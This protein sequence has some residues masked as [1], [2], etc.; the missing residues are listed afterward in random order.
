MQNPIL[1]VGST[2]KTLD[3]LLKHDIVS[4]LDDVF[5]DSSMTFQKVIDDIGRK[6]GIIFQPERC[7]G[8]TC[9]S[10]EEEVCA[11]CADESYVYDADNKT[12]ICTVCSGRDISQTVTVQSN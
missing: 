11:G 7:A 4:D 6:V 1:I 2:Q 10:C 8:I 3:E 9:S 5:F 12:A